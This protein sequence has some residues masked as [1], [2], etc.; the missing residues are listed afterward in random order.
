MAMLHVGGWYDPMLDGTLAILI[1]TSLLLFGL[2]RTLALTGGRA[3]A[4]A[5]R[6]TD[7]RW[8]GAFILP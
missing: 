1:D 6:I 7:Q 8:T 2:I 3:H 5:A 4:L